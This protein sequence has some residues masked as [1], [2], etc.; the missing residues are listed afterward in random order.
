MPVDYLIVE[1]NDAGLWRQWLHEHFEDTSGVWLRLYKKASGVASVTYAEALD[2]ALCY[3]WIDGQVNKYDEQSYLQ[4]FT[5]RRARSMWSKR[6]VEYI[7]RLTA[8]G[9]MMPSGI[10]EV[11]RA[12]AD[13]RWQAAYDSPKNMVI[14]EDFLLAL[15]ENPQASATY[16]TLSKS[17]LYHI[18]FQLQ[19][20][21]LPET[22]ARRIAGFVTRLAQGDK[23]T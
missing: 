1:F 19:N 16:D 10:A 8:A 12:Q 14:P 7:A 17:S 5:P 3:G 15:R 23:L 6:N 18:G 20:A 9:L 22:R 11:E 21:K 13:G 4:K 2:H